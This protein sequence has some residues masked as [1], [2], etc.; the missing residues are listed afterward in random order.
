MTA[1]FQYAPVDPSNAYGFVAVCAGDG[2]EQLFKDLG[3]TN[4]VKGGAETMAAHR[5]SL[6]ASHA[7]PAKTVLVLPNNKNIIMAAEQAIDLAD[8]EVRVLPTKTIPEGLSAMY[9]M[10]PS[11]LRKT[12]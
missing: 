8:R 4:V 12:R 5:W 10:S 11:M 6:S 2:V 1:G 9:S 3:V 7:T